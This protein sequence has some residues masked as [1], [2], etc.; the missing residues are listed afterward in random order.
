MVFEVNP[1][2]PRIE[3]NT[4]VLSLLLFPHLVSPMLPSL[5]SAPKCCTYSNH[6]LLKRT[7]RELDVI[8]LSVLKLEVKEEEMGVLQR[9]REEGGNGDLG[10]QCKVGR[11]ELGKKR[12]TRVLGKGWI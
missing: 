9:R 8:P 1:S 6:F 2:K 11:R 4:S 3:F 10:D 7:V 12:G 5:F